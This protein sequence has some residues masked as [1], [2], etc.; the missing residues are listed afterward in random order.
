MYGHWIAGKL[1]KGPGEGRIA[2]TNPATEEVIDTVPSG[3]LEDVEHAVHSAKTAFVAWKK[4]S[5]IEKAELLHEVAAKIRDMRE[6]LARV[7]T[8]E[9]G[10]PFK[11]NIDEVT[12]VAACFDYYAEIG[13][14]Y[15]GRVIAPVE[16][17]QLSLVIKEPFGVTACITPWNYPLLLMS[18][19]V[20][21]ALAAGNTIII[22]PSSVTPLSTIALREAFGILPAGTVNIITGG[23]E[24]LGGA[25]IRHK[26][27]RMIAFTGSVDAGRKI[28]LMAAGEFKKVHLELGGKDPFVVCEDADLEVASKGVAWA[29]FLN[30]GQVCTSTERIYVHQSIADEFIERFVAYTKTLRLGPGIEPTTDIGPMAGDSYRKKVEGQIQDALAAG[31]LLKH[32]GKRPAHLAKGYFL[33]PTVL[34]NVNHSMAI[35]KEET[36][37]PVAPIMTFRTFDEAIELANDSD[38][39][40]GA[41][42]YTNDAKKVKRFFQDVKAGTIWINDPLTDNDAGPFG[43]MKSTG[44][45]RELGEEGIE[46]FRETKHVHWDFEMRAKEWWYPY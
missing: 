7:L 19:K 23:G 27:V 6:D 42:I 32:G 18:W 22:K 25:L 46:E 11:E 41:C 34:I 4:A 44:G 35:M 10:K 15:M 1:I 43:G 33:E 5:G 37:G 24:K 26:D 30:A 2:V 31:A 29:A 21:P 20:A 38:Y 36:F 3:T 28:A 39:G 40:L 45:G 17:T 14:N 13:R 12:W 9:G 16:P 8:L